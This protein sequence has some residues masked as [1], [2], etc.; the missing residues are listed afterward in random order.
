MMFIIIIAITRP[1]ENISDVE[2]ACVLMNMCAVFARADHIA[3]DAG[4]PG[5]GRPPLP[6]IS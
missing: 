5:P 1:G 6:D 4:G 3:G 2:R